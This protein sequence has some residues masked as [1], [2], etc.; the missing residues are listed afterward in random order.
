M[1]KRSH[2]RSA[3][4]LASLFAALTLGAARD[5]A[6]AADNSGLPML[7]ACQPATQPVLPQRWRAVGLMLPYL[8][9]QLVVG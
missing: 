2:L 4:L 1:R 6:T 7:S 8:R 5:R 3:T 9:E